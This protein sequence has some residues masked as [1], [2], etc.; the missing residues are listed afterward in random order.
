MV[1]SVKWNQNGNWVL[2]AS[3]DQIIKVG[4]QFF[5]PQLSHELIWDFFSSEIYNF[6]RKFI[7]F[8][9]WLMILLHHM[10][11]GLWH[12]GYEGTWIFSWPSKGRDWL[13]KFPLISPKPTLSFL[14]ISRCHVQCVCKTSI[15]KPQLYY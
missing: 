9:P 14:I 4:G 8:L 12:K 10:L 2:T 13:V 3:K 6:P 1:L 5:A 15:P 7:I 11:S